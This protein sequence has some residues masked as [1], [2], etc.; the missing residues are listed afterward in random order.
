VM[1]ASV[2]LLLMFVLLSVENW[3]PSPWAEAACACSQEKERTRTD[4]EHIAVLHIKTSSFSWRCVVSKT[5]VAS[6]AHG[7]TMQFGM[8][9]FFKTWQYTDARLLER[10][11]Q[12]DEQTA[13]LE[14]LPVSKEK[15]DWL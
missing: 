5:D 8:D 6:V 12:R 14:Y 10:P 11:I 15:R 7:Q 9:G 13:I 1:S 2:N 4:T 3:W